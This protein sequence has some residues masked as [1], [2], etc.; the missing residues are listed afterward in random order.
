M[1]KVRSEVKVTRVTHV[2]NCNWDRVLDVFRVAT[3]QNVIHHAICCVMLLN[4]TTNIPTDQEGGKCFIKRA[5]L[6]VK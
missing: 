2:I 5:L 3:G 6:M 4:E 1:L